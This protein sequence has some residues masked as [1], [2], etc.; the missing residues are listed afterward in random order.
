M[1]LQC[2]G[3]NFSSV[4][5]AIAISTIPKLNK[6]RDRRRLECGGFINVTRTVLLSR[7]RRNMC[8][9]LV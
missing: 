5:I 4:G 6:E 3:R 2:R 1:E 9:G 8:Q 7:L